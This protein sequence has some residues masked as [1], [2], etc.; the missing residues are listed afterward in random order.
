MI[1]PA[2]HA[3]VQASEDLMERD[4]KGTLQLWWLSVGV[5]KLVSVAWEF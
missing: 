5:Q 1:M 2:A 4:G 3:L